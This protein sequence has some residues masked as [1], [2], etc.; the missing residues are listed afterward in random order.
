MID[1]A[2]VSAPAIIDVTHQHV[3]DPAVDDDSA[4]ACG[5]LEPT[6]AALARRG[7]RGMI[8]AEWAI[9]IIAAVSMAGIVLYLVVHGPLKELLTQLI[10]QIIKTVAA[11]G[12]R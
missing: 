4:G 2:D 5:A 8:T 6:G 7:E 12:V 1:N 3:L 11:N 10:L 9:G